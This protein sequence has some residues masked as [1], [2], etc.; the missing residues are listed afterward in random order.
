GQGQ[1]PSG[2]NVYVAWGAGGSHPALD[3]TRSPE[4]GES[5]ETP[6][7]ILGEARLPSLVSAGPQ[8]AAGPDGLVCAVCDWTTQQDSSGDMIGQVVAVCSTDAGRSFA[9]PV[10][11]GA[12]AAAIAL[13][14]DVRPNS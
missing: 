10:H 5:S 14:G 3:F 9:A 7:S 6:R 13:P 11:L 4:G 2:H 8:L 1:T 12:E